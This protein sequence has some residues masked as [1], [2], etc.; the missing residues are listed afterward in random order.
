MGKA[1][2][3]VAR[4]EEEAPRRAIAVRNLAIQKMNADM[5]RPVG[6]GG[7]MP[8]KDGFLRASFTAVIGRDPPPMTKA[9]STPTSYDPGQ[10]TLVL[11]GAPLDG[12]LTFAWTMEYAMRQHY[13]FVGEDKLG[14]TYNQAG[15][16]WVTTHTPNWQRYINDAAAEIRKA[17]G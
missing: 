1:T 12:A 17:V 7:Q 3:I 4:F 16:H 15:Y 6:D 8:I 10:I 11:E 9:G 14:R 13:G 2:E 5:Q